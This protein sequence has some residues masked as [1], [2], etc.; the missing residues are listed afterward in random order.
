MKR[1]FYTTKDLDDAKLISDEVHKKGIDDYHFFVLSRDE[2]GIQTHHLHGSP[3][4]EKTKILAASQRTVLL[5]A[6]VLFTAVVAFA[7][8]TDL[9]AH[10]H[11]LPI[12]LIFLVGCIILFIIKTTSRSFDSYFGDLF[13]E[14]LNAG[15]VVIVIDVPKVQADEVESIMNLHSKAKFIADSS[16]FNSP[17]PK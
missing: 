15:E 5:T 10:F 11:L 12:L 3:K 2:K 4:L 1:L 17:I 13:N 6:L 14:H 8:F 9:F 7:V 16:N